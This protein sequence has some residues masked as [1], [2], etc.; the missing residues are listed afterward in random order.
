MDGC[1]KETTKQI[2][3]ITLQSS[4]HYQSPYFCTT[5]SGGSSAQSFNRALDTALLLPIDE[6]VLFA[7]D[8]YL[9]LPNSR[10]VLEEGLARADYVAPYLHPDKFIPATS[11]GNPE[12]DDA[13]ST[14]TRIFKTQSSFWMMCNSTTMTFATSVRVLKEDETTW[15]KYTTGTY[16]RDYDAFIDLRSRGRTLV[17]PIPTIATHTE[18]QWLAPLIGTSFNSWETV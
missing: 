13:G 7:E 15:R 3:E 6:Y 12:V 11:G 4:E 5:I 8:D 16:P 10:M 2:E 9:W 14:L 18:I 1:T 17:Q